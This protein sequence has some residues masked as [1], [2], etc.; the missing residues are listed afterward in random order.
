MPGTPTICA[1]AQGVHD[2]DDLVGFSSRAEAIREAF[3]NRIMVTGNECGL[4]HHMPQQA[5]DPRSSIYTF[6]RW[7]FRQD[8]SEGGRGP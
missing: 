1:F 3:E 4:K 6:A 5:Q 2:G 7:G 8:L